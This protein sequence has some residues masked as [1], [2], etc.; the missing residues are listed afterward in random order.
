MINKKDITEIAKKMM[1]KHQ[2]LRDPQIIHPRRDWIIGVFLSLAAFA[3]IAWWSGMSYLNYSNISVI[4]SVEL[5]DTSVVY[6][7]GQVNAALELFKEQTDNYNQLLQNRVRY[8]PTIVEEEVV[9]TT[10]ENAT[11]SATT[12]EEIVVT[13]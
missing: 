8:V 10:T 3:G 4:E 9:A 13:E 11:S 12:T 7:E 5:A 2:G 1:R 6:K